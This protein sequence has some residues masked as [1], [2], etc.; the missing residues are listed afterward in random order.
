MTTMPRRVTFK[1]L[2]E[3]VNNLSDVVGFPLEMYGSNHG[4]AIFSG[5]GDRRY[6]KMLTPGYLNNRELYCWLNGVWLRY[7]QKELFNGN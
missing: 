3:I 5:V 6:R 2:E 1:D 4:H 7:D